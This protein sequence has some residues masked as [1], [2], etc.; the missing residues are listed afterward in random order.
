M[1]FEVQSF[2]RFGGL[3]FGLGSRVEDIGYRSL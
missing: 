3:L 2:A 1:Q